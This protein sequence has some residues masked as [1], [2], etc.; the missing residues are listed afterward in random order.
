MA[1]LKQIR[2]RI[3]GV[4]NTR[5]IT[6]AMKMVAAAR[7]RKA[8]ENMEAARPYSAKLREVITSL[9]ARTE[10]DVHPLLI[11]REPQKIGIIC[12]TSDRGLAGGFNATICRRTELL[13]KEHSGKEVELLTI[14]RK[15][16]DFF[17]KRGMKIHK[18]YTN[19]F[20]EMEFS[21]AT[22]IGKELSSYYI[23]G[24]F[25]R[26]YVVFNEFKN[27]MQQNLIS[28]RLLPI[29][30]NQV[31]S[32]WQAVDYI[33]EPDAN[34]VLDSILPLYINIQTWR[35]L[36][37]SYASEQAARMSAMDKAT[38]NADELVG[39][40]KLQFN[41]ARQTAITT[42][43]LEIVGGAEGLK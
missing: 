30:P 26:I 11:S 20:N 15:G 28:E 6:R 38:E 43:L 25:D 4:Q 23:D 13:L 17:K 12:V 3:T 1:S 21:S 31:M 24:S 2:R 42:E 41:K 33:Y 32:A 27:A 7:M 36:L 9:V 40:L 37:E 5:Q 16:N 10:S 19:V 14:G 39:A 18:F 22:R 8:Q 29:E 34:S 35:V